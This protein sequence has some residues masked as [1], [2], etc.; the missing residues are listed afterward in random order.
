LIFIKHFGIIH[1][2]AQKLPEEGLFDNKRRKYST[3]Q[4]YQYK[5][6]K[7]Q[8]TTKE[9]SVHPGSKEENLHY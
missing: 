5:I 6:S 2:E 8:F 3:G 4:S 9:I 1:P 7:I